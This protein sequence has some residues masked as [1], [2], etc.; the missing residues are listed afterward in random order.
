[1]HWTRAIFL[2]AILALVATSVTAQQGR[3]ALGGDAVLWA[4]GWQN[5]QGVVKLHPELRLS[6]GCGV[7]TGEGSALE[8][9]LRPRPV[10]F[11]SARLFSVGVRAYPEVQEGQSIQGFFGLEL[12]VENYVQSFTGSSDMAFPGQMQW[13]RRDIR[14]VAGAEWRFHPSYSLAGH[15]A[16]GHS[17]TDE[18]MGFGPDLNRALQ[19]LPAM[20]RMIG[21]EFLRWF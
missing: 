1:M 21:V 17:R 15:V 13:T 20:P 16:V 10:D 14:M 19:S 12:A 2:G 3:V 4:A 11:E 9:V 18:G 6:M 8:G 7:L 5:V